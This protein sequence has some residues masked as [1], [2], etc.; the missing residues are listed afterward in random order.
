MSTYV[1]KETPAG[2]HTLIYKNSREVRL[3]SAYD[4][5]TEAARAVEGFSAGRSS[6]IAVYGLGLGYHVRSIKMKFPGLRIL[7]VEKDP[8]VIGIVRKT[9]PEHLDGVT[10]LTKIEEASAVFEEID[11]AGFRGIA[12]YTHR[13]SYL[14]FKEFYDG[15]M[16]DMSQYA[17]SK[18]SD[19]LTRYEF[20][21][22]WVDNILVN[23][24][25]LFS[26]TLVGSMFGAFRGY[27]GIIV[28]AGPSLRGN[29]RIVQRLRDRALI[30]A[31]DT[32]ALALQRMGVEPHVIMTL[33]AQKYSIKHFSVSARTAPLSWQIW[34]AARP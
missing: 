24:R 25:Y 34:F 9:Y 8:E 2:K 7:V 11:M 12:H 18:I 26:S 16:R 21:E 1:I 19:L 15:F 28:S 32:A 4:P 14:L 5:E 30:V 20:E 10:V 23:V 13:P 22:R 31:V 27:P 6:L 29:A 33:D 17:S 3:H